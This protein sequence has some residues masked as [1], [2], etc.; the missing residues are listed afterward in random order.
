MQATPLQTPQLICVSTVCLF[1]VLLWSACVWGVST[2]EWCCRSVLSCCTAFHDMPHALCRVARVT[3]CTPFE[4]VKHF[5]KSCY[6]TCSKVQAVA[7]VRWC[8]TLSQGGN[9]CHGCLPCVCACCKV[10]MSVGVLTSPIDR[11]SVGVIIIVPKWGIDVN[12]NFD[13]F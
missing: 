13:I 11:P 10:Q 4:Y 6:S 9:P 5:Q 3:P 2:F 12:N 8:T 7:S 1:C